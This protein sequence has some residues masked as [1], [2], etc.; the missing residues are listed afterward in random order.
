[1][2]I[3]HGRRSFEVGADIE[4][5]AVPNRSFSLDTVARAF[6]A[7]FGPAPFGQ[8]F[9]TSEQE[10]DLALVKY[11]TFLQGPGGIV[12]SGDPE[13]FE[14]VEEQRRLNGIWIARGPT[15]QQTILEAE[16]AFSSQDYEKS[17]ELFEKIQSDLGAR[18]LA[19][20]AYARQHRSGR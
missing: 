1:L 11:S 10:I 5:G 17:A 3:Y 14:L 15:F 18:E 8:T 13:A 2:T 20:L 19:K 12:L 6:G 4:R 9:G 16:V 7:A